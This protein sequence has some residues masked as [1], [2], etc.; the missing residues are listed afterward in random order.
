MAAGPGAE[1]CVGAAAFPVQVLYKD[2][3]VAEYSLI[4]S[5]EFGEGPGLGHPEK[6]FLVNL[7]QLLI[8]G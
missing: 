7:N 6:L 3:G 4:L 5:T 8:Q 2:P 1:P